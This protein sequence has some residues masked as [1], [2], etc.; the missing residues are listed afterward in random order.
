MNSR[1]AFLALAA[2]LLAVPGTGLAGHSCIEDSE[3]DD[4]VFC[5]GNELCRPFAEGHDDHGCLPGDPPS[6]KNGKICR[7]DLDKCARELCKQDAD[8]DD[9]R[10]CNGVETCDPLGEI[11][12][13]SG[14]RRGSSPCGAHERCSEP[15]DQCRF[16]CA[17]KDFDGDGVDAAQC[18]G[19]DCDDLDPVR[20]PAAREICDAENKDEDCDPTTFGTKDVD[21]D[22][23]IAEACCNGQS[24]GELLCGTDCDDSAPG[25]SREATELCNEQDDDCDGRIDEGAAVRLFRDEDGDLHGNLEGD[26]VLGCPGDPRTARLKNDCDDTN[27]AI[28]PGSQLCDADGKVQICDPVIDSK[29]NVESVYQ[30]GFCTPGTDCYPQPNGTGLCAI[31]PAVE[32]P[33]G[34]QPL[35]DGTCQCGGGEPLPCPGVGCFPTP[36][37]CVCG[38]E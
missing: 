12:S 35:P 30:E 8:C 38:P 15:K 29:G 3:C 7:E 11:G 19:T 33:I 22:G 32:C 34:C 25:V 18:G 14:C 17:D 1:A 27:P 6:C 28:Q 20:S 13:E 31:A 9:G 10:F 2:L 21:G 5:N 23:S 24:N 36:E 37:G 4:G 16:D 26:A